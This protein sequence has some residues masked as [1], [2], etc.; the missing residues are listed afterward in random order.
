M[1]QP[2]SYTGP[3]IIVIASA[4]LGFA[5]RAIRCPTEKPV[6]HGTGVSVH[7]R[8]RLDPFPAPSAPRTAAPR[9]EPVAYPEPLSLPS[10]IPIRLRCGL[11]RASEIS[12]VA[13]DRLLPRI[14]DRDSI[15]TGSITLANVYT[16]PRRG[17]IQ[18]RSN[19]IS[20]R[21]R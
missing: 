17:T 18:R 7:A 21:T 20:A 13:V 3:R 14:G 1:L 15:E 5:L 9:Y 16:S 2:F 8:V 11:S 4:R 12:S 19:V 6:S 10:S